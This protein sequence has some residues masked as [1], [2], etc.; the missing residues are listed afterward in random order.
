MR[1]FL[2]F[3][4]LTFLTSC[5]S[6]K[7][8]T[9]AENPAETLSEAALVTRRLIESQFSTAW[10]DARA[11]I[12]LESP[13]MNVSGNAFIRLEKDK[14][15][16][17]SVKKFGFEAARALITPD[18]FFVL[19]RL[20]NEFTA[21]PLSYIEKTYKIPARFDLL[22]QVVL[23][24]PIFFDRELELS[25]EASLLRLAGKNNR[26]QSDYWIES[27]AF[28]LKRMQLRE[29]S[30]DRS[31]QV[32][33]D[34]FKDVGRKMPFSH[35]RTV[36]ISSPATGLARIGLDFS[37]LGFSGPLEMPFEVPAR[38]KRSR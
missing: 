23:G 17:I 33:M 13:Q 7:T 18:S 19:N 12:K 20:Q 28:L 6:K 36:E 16:W 15:L 34:N 14:R 22:Q 26:W 5:G 29:I 11:N 25:Q 32:F 9:T 37:Q 24:N 10:L 30:A 1:I 3:L 35:Q 8:A 31:L 2:F 38:F 27:P 4:S 21:E